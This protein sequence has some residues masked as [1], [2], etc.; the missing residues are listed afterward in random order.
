VLAA[1]ASTA[2]DA[3]VSS[4]SQSGSGN[5]RKK[6]ARNGTIKQRKEINVKIS[7]DT[8]VTTKMVEGVKSSGGS[9]NAG[10]EETEDLSGLQLQSDTELRKGKWTVSMQDVL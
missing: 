9:E 2:T 3:P 7:S 1:T 4:R 8:V 6:H 5:K 10:S